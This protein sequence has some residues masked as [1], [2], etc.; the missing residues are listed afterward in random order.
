MIFPNLEKESPL[1]SMTETAKDD[2]YVPERKANQKKKK[3][4]KTYNTGDSPVVTHLSTSP[5][6]SSLSRAERTG[7]RVFYYLWSYVLILCSKSLYVP[8]SQLHLPAISFPF[9]FTNQPSS[10]SKMAPGNTYAR[11]EI[12]SGLSCILNMMMPIVLGCRGRGLF[13]VSHETLQELQRGWR[14]FVYLNKVQLHE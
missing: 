10:Q 9:P 8:T 3:G 13:V 11:S 6:I 7:C 14:F 5:A 4:P 1:A 12:G 2:M